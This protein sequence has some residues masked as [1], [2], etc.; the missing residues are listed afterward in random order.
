MLIVVGVSGRWRRFGRG[1]NGLGR[2]VGVVV[3]SGDGEVVRVVSN[4]VR[5]RRRRR[6]LPI[7]RV[8]IAG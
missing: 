7:V 5:R 8:V 1:G 2:L 4:R 6:R 3:I